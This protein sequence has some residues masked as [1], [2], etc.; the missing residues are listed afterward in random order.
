[1]RK[2]LPR[3]S[4]RRSPRHPGV[5]FLK[6]E[7]R[8]PHPTWTSPHSWRGFGRH[9][10]ARAPG[11]DSGGRGG[12][13]LGGSAPA[14]QALWSPSWPRGSCRSQT[15]PLRRG[16]VGPAP[17]PTAACCRTARCASFRAPLLFL[18]QVGLKNKSSDPST[19]TL[20]V[21]PTIYLFN[22]KT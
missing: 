21:C 13:R 4:Q 22:S 11:R 2:H 14:A 7:R 19:R 12:R 17:T 18:V 15:L 3:S 9:S 8:S 1:M 20:Y 16:A 6:N 5:W 10:P